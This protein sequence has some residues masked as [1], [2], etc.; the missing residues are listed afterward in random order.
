MNLFRTSLSIQMAV[1]TFL[2]IF[3]GL[4]LGDYCS[5]F[6]PWANAYI[7]ILKVTAIPYLMAAII[8]GVGQMTHT[9][10]KEILKKGS[11]FIGIAFAINIAM[12]YFMTFLFP[13]PKGA[14]QASYIS[15]QSSQINFA[16]LLIP[17]NVFYALSNNIIPAVVIFSLFIGLSLMHIKEKKVAM[18]LLENLIEA[19]TR[20][21]KWISRITPL[22]TLII[23]ANQVG[24]IHFTTVKQIGT[25]II[26][27]IIGACLVVFWIFPRLTNMLTSIPAYK[28]LR[29][30]LP[31]LILAYTTNVVIVCL[32]YIIALVQRETQL[33]YPHDE[34]ALA[35][36]QGIV[37]VLFNLP[38]GSI[39]LTFFIMFAAIFYNFPLPLK[40]HFELFATTFL[41]GLGSVGIGSWINSLTFLLESL[42][43]PLDAINLYLTTVPFTSGFQSMISAMEISSLSL[44]I[45]LACRKLIIF[46]WSRVVTNAAFAVIPLFLFIGI[47][48]SFNPLPQ[49]QNQ[50]K[51]IYDLS[52]RSDI[53]TRLYALGEK[54]PAPS[55]QPNEDVL[56]R[57]LRTKTLRVG[58]YPCT[59]P[60]SF[61]NKKGDLV[62]YDISFAYELAH[63]LGVHLEFI[64]LNYANLAQELNENLYD[65]GMSAV[66][67]NEQR[68]KALNFSTS[69]IEAK[70]V[71]VANNIKRREF[72]S[73]PL[74][75]SATI[76]VFRGSIF[77]QLAKELF[78]KH[79]IIPLDN[80]DEFADKNAPDLLL[81]DEQEAISWV[82]RHPHFNVIYPNPSL[83][84]DSFA[85]PIKPGAERF[86]NYLNQWIKLKQNEGFA[87]RQYD[88]WILRK[89]EKQEEEEEPRWSIIRNML[90]WVH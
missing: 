67:I 78:P 32:P 28:W 13:H 12:I 56:D 85:Y 35:P 65:I 83:G 15:S 81:W 22:G 87:Q 36:T 74:K 90:H 52:A 77:E 2:G 71:F 73:M 1:A 33:L 84:I 82:L 79:D 86:L 39:F 62:G 6:S 41:T 76:G 27:Y 88:L 25:Y 20:I 50:S 14:Q 60:F 61:Y 30:M 47:V 37:S 58:Y 72:T 54:I 31:I 53:P 42:G 55:S 19:L 63:D 57:I 29:D 9:Q 66:S 48:K 11:I 75:Q 5:V 34:K 64:P 43:L 80:Y 89:P 69:Y 49:I 59:T 3:L 17:D 16:E 68:L 40:S 70:I 7:M 46:R 4:F 23:I 24:T 44:L 18:S 10:G 38:L 45:T 51:T 21:T 8:H 26:I